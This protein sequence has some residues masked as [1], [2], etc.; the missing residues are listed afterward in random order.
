M[1]KE[2]EYQVLMIDLSGHV[3]KEKSCNDKVS[4]IEFYYDL[5][6]QW[7]DNDSEILFLEN[8]IEVG[9]HYSDEDGIKSSWVYE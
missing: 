3:V 8:G 6:T 9:S 1:N 7:G 4:A 5:L 2:N